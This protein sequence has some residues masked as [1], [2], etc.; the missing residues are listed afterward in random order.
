[1][2]EMNVEK[3]KQKQKEFAK[4]TGQ[5]RFA[6][7]DGIC[8]RCKSNIYSPMYWVRDQDSNIFAR[9][10]VSK[11]QAL[12]HIE[13]NISVTVTGISVDKAST[14]LVTGCPHCN[15]SYCD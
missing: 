7:A 15:R 10:K 2:P 5:P 14:E 4:E 3:S 11:E 12:D 13:N 8:Y 1:M 6:P 9:K